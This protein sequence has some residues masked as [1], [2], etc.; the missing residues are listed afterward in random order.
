MA[1]PAILSRT[2]STLCLLGLWS[3]SISAQRMADIPRFE[4]ASV[5][6]S[7]PVAGQGVFFGMVSDA[8][9]FR[10]SFVTL[11]D[12][13]GKAFGVDVSRISGGPA[14]VSTDRY[15]VV[16]TLP[17]DTLQGQ[18]PTL[19]Q[20]LLAE[21]FGLT[22]RRDTRMSSMYALVPAKGGPKLKRSE[23]PG[24]PPPTGQ[25]AIFSAPAVVGA[26]G[27]GLRLCCGRAQL[28][29]ISMSG[30]AG[31]LSSQAD[32]PVQDYTGIQGLFDVSLEWTPDD[33]R[34]QPDGVPSVTGPS[35]Y[36]AIQEQLGLRLEPRTAPS[37]YLVI[38]R[39]AKP[40]QD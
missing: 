4:V 29:G 28:V 13:V 30:L 21:R 38:E 1:S 36:S 34:P 14:W 2:I 19:L 20:T 35:I 18:I 31:L 8:S 39:A 11:A 5:K 26:N 32:R 40:A 23:A 7:R 37:D 6:P 22:V 12:L 17:K 25:R 27:G 15:D 16:A 10:G 33:A 3:L 24:T 9:R